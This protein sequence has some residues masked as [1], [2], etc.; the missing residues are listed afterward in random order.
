MDGL[1]AAA[2]G[3]PIFCI[4]SEPV[5]KFEKIGMAVA[6]LAIQL[7]GGFI[8]LYDF[9]GTVQDAPKEVGE[10]VLDLK[11]L[12]RTLN[13]LI[14]RKDPSPYIQDA[15]TICH[16]KVAVRP[17]TFDLSFNKQILTT[18]DFSEGTSQHSART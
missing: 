16:D 9:W 4:C 1:S 14:N 10:I 18:A 12:S 13:E 3:K 5:L 15:L 7:G 8:K 17:L 2:S 11:L 6:S